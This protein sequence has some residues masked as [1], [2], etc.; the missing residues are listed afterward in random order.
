MTALAAVPFAQPIPESKA[1]ADFNAATRDY[2]AMHHRLETL[3]GPITADSTVESINRS[4]QALATAIRVERAKAQQGDLFGPELAVALRARV[5]DA[6][7]EHGF[8][9]ADLLASQVVENVDPAAAHLGVNGT[10]PW[11]FATAVFPCVIAALPPLPAELQYHIVGRDL[12]LVDAHASLVV[13]ILPNV[14][15]IVTRWDPHGEG[16]RR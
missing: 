9:A 16:I 15:P 11:I 6:L 2:A 3:V 13:D 5:N 7:F 1:I 12:L 4:M 14:L 8:T 10:F